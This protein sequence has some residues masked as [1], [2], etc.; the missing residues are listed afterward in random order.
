[1]HIER[2]REGREQPTAGLAASCMLGLAW[3]GCLTVAK[4]VA[5]WPTQSDA[6]HR[7][8]VAQSLSLSMNLVD[9]H[10]CAFPLV[11]LCPL[12]RQFQAMVAPPS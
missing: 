9:F 7:L 10:V 8:T 3:L 2:V 11:R 4:P 1:M 12:R 5:L 6:W